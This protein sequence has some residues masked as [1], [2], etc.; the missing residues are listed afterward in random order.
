MPDKHHRDGGMK[1]PDDERL[2]D[3]GEPDVLPSQPEGERGT[4]EQTPNAR[5]PGQAEGTREEVDEAL[6]EQRKNGK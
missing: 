1:M 5:T 6:R 3:D 4:E 2:R